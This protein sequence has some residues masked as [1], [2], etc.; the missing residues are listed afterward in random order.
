LLAFASLCGGCTEWN[1]RRSAFPNYAEFSASPLAG[2]G[3]LPSNLVPRSARD[4]RV[5]YNIDTT[6]VEAEFDFSAADEPMIESP[7]LSPDLTR[8][9]QVV[10]Q[11]QAEPPTPSA[12]RTLVRC[13]STKVEFLLL[14]RHSHARYWTDSD[15]EV[16]ARSC[17]H[18]LTGATG[19]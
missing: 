6:E 4:I 8:F 1:E 11:G 14:E 7:F 17:P 19:A 12:S 3:L 9:R 2:N 15:R 16:R 10:K 13:G 5:V 18:T